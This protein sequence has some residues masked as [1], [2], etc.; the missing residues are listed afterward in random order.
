MILWSLSNSMSLTSPIFL[1]SVPITSVPLNL[2][3]SHW[4]FVCLDT[5]WALPA[6]LVLLALGAGVDGAV[7]A[8]GVV[9]VD[10]ADPAGGVGAF[11]IA[12]VNAN[13]LT[14]AAGMIVFSMWASCGGDFSIGLMVAGSLPASCGGN[15]GTALVFP[16]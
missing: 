2:V 15:A 1:S 8:G 9:V 13:V 12:L 11:A 6:A 14:A 16:R 4:S 10:G 7:A 5:K 3:A